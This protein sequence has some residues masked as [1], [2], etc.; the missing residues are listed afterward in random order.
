M[1]VCIILGLVLMTLVLV[2]LSCDTTNQFD[3]TSERF[4]PDY[5][6]RSSWGANVADGAVWGDPSMSSSIDAN[7]HEYN[8]ELP[9]I[10]GLYH[11]GFST[12]ERLKFRKSE[13][14]TQQQFYYSPNIK[15]KYGN[16]VRTGGSLIDLL[17][18]NQLL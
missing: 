10:P 18:P 16:T 7:W 4:N 3:R 8:S 9:N 17:N 15:V 11:E 2:W 5:A 6:Y 1:S 13:S 12:S 14:F